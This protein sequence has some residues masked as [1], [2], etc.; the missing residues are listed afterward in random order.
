[1]SN[2]FKS[3][4][5]SARQIWFQQ[6]KKGL[7]ARILRYYGEG[8]SPEVRDVMAHI[9]KHPEKELPLGMTPPYE[10]V[11][12][13]LPQSVQ[14]D[15]DKASGLPFVTATGHRIFFPRDST[16]ADV[17]SAVAIAQM[18]Q[19]DRSP[20]RYVGDGFNVDAGDIGVFIG[21]SNGLF[22]VSLIGRLS[23][24]YLFE[25]DQA[26]HEPLRHTFAPWGD[27]V[28]ILPL[29]VGSNA[30]AEQT[31]LDEFFKS[32]PAP[33]Y[34]QAD[35]EG[36]EMNVLRGAQQLLRNSSKLRLSLCTYHNRADFRRFETLLKS[37]GYEIGHSPGFYFIGVRAPY[38]R[39][40]ILY[41]W[42]TVNASR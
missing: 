19:D 9:K 24:A 40:G 28:E 31:S 5:L 4:L 22:G 16:V 7:R 35:V 42:R 18:E 23:K 30:T 39:R 1:M 14:V 15:T 12:E 34:I 29:F 36:A 37:Q 38:F 17:Q 8:E 41:G 2:I 13:Y 21:A 11:G 6:R 3:A 33:N 26:W 10:W 20:H 25:P 27:K 32:R